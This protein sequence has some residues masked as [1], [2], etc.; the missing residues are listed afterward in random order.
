[1]SS[2]AAEDTTSEWMLVDA[3]ACSSSSALGVTQQSSAPPQPPQP[4][5]QLSVRMAAMALSP[6]FPMIPQDNTVQLHDHFARLMSDDELTYATAITAL[7]KLLSFADQD[8]VNATVEQIANVPRVIP[9]LVHCLK[10]SNN[11]IIQVRGREGGVRP[12][13]MIKIKS[14]QIIGARVSRSWE[15][16]F[17]SLCVCVCVSLV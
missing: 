15:C 16:V 10:H 2:D 5:Q 11:A 3:D 8:K 7:R 17:L 1:M 4:P 14:N 6:E 13:W 12:K 9:R